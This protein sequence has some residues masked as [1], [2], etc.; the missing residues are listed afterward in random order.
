MPNPEMVE[1]QACAGP[2]GRV[3]LLGSMM[4]LLFRRRRPD[5]LQAAA[6]RLHDALVERVR[7]PV[8]YTAQRVPDTFEGRFDLLVLHVAIVLRALAR[9][10]AD[11]Q[12]LSQALV[13]TMFARFDV[14]MREL[15]VSDMGVPKRMKR[16]A[17]A[18]KGRTAAYHLA[19]D[20][21]DQDALA[22]AIGRNVLSDAADGA[23]LAAYA[24]R[25][26]AALD[27]TPVETW[28][29]ALI[30]SDPR[31]TGETAA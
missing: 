1:N 12:A 7:M 27:G 21:Q 29:G 6:E 9:H 15:G 23:P 20:A 25:V 26:N 14:A 18:F 30:E 4:P 3:A 11:G 5:P 31:M 13:D 19:L 10:G 16:L 22:A 2:T 24:V 17:E 28:A 8:F